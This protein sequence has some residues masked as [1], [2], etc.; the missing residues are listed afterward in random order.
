MYVYLVRH[1]EAKPKGVDAAR[2]LS[3]KGGSD[4]RRL[5]AFLEP[6]R[7]TVGVIWQSGK[8]RAAQTAAILSSAIASRD[9][10]VEHASLSPNDP[11]GPIVEALGA[12][13]D[14][15]MIV[16]HLP[17]LAKLASALIAGHEQRAAVA[18]PAGGVICIEREGEAGWALRWMVVP[19]LLR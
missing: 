8:T 7:L 13:A 2:G 18:F 16:G 3:A 11:V 1:G 14:D 15:V 10:V 4:V 6:Q 5:A 17:S 12:T 9:G 19:E